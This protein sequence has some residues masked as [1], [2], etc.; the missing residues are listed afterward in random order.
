MTLNDSTRRAL[1]TGYQFLIA[2]IGI[3]PVL[4]EVIPAHSPLAAQLAVVLAFLAAVTKVL[5]TL[6]DRGLIPAFLKAPAS[7]GANPVPDPGSAPGSV[8][9][10]P[11]SGAP[12]AFLG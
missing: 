7:P 8:A 3:V 12:D 6:E 9:P 5:N 11:E 1:R 4:A 10:G 2:C